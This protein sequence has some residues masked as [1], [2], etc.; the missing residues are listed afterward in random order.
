[1]L[2]EN[3]I[4]SLYNEAVENGLYE[5]SPDTWNQFLLHSFNDNL[6]TMGQFNE[7]FQHEE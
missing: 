6:I 4:A 3:D 7:L 1:M 2:T 5:E